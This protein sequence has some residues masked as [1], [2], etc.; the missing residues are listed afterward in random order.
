MSEQI[1]NTASGISLTE[2]RAIPAFSRL[3]DPTRS[4]LEG[5][6][7][8]HPFVLV[9][10]SEFRVTWLSDDLH[11]VVGGTA[12]TMGRL[13]AELL[14]GL[15]PADVAEFSRQTR[16]LIDRML[17]KKS[18]QRAQLDL[19]RNGM[20]LPL[21]ISSF[22]IRDAQDNDLIVCVAD[23]HQ[24]E[25]SLTRKNQELESCMRGVSHD[26]CSPLAS[27]LGFSQLLRADYEGVLAGKG[28][29]FL[30]RI[31]QAGRH[32]QQLLHHL[33]EYSRIGEVPHCRVRVNPMPIL[34][35]LRSELK[36]ELDEQE[37]DLLL[38]E[39]P[40]PLLCDRTGLYQLFSNLIGNAIQHSRPTSKGRIEVGI[41]TLA[42]G[43][44]I[45]VRDNGCGIAREDHD[46]IF[47]V[48]ETA[49]KPDGDCNSSG[50]GLS[51]VKKIVEAHSGR[52]SVES[53]LGSGARFIVWLPKG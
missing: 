43:W 32:M 51:I 10:D 37:F 2:Y 40:P 16:Q 28:L 12:N 1:Q 3:D 33:L 21:E 41:E 31:E 19:R 36:L 46:R 20:A 24:S 13:A 15:W 38:P 9:V 26:L 8:L 39:Q 35:Q 50:L 44:Q 48:F 23:H 45:S 27:L 52:L 29:H 11:I 5:F 53:E 47:D 49:G 17:A 22:Q 42:D 18:I 4:I 30:E 6:A 14:E 34:E 25:N 7:S